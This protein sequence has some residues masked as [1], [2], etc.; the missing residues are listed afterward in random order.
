[1]DKLEI[2]WPGGKIE[3]LSN[4]TAD[5]F[6]QLREGAGIVSSKAVETGVSPIPR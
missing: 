5:R 6:Y 4:L 2:F 3:T 1:M